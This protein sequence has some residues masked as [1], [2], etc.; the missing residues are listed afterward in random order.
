MS[1]VTGFTIFETATG[2]K[3]ATLPLTVPIG[4]TVEAYER[5][6]HKVSWTWETGELE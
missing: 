1:M 4:M 5:A 6:G 3:L 2:R